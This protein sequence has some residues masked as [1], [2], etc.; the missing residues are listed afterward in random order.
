M[1]YLVSSIYYGLRDLVYSPNKSLVRKG[2]HIIE[3]LLPDEL[4][5][6]LLED[7]SVKINKGEI[8]WKDEESSDYRIM[9]YNCQD[10]E[11]LK[12]IDKL[13]ES[14]FE[15]YI[16]SRKSFNFFRMANVVLPKKGNKGSGGGWHRDSLNRRQLKLMIYLT[17]VNDANGPFEY[18]KSS[19]RFYHKLRFNMFRQSVRF[20]ELSSV[21]KP[22]S[23]VLV[24]KKG[25]AIIFD[26]S[27]VHRGRPIMSGERYAL[28][29]YTFAGAI[30]DHLQSLI[31]VLSNDE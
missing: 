10:K 28:T 13:V 21:L 16:D 9:G 3:N 1:K 8:S 17:D 24:G 22:E 25:T 6:K 14:N 19:H 12:N 5:D 31:D 4:C 20:N 18:K 15:R 29:Y 30:P 23:D 27:G 26:S 7:I 11:I 2:Y